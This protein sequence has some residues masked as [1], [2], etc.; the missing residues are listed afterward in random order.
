MNNNIY[1]TLLIS[2]KSCGKNYKKILIDIF[3]S[4]LIYKKSNAIRMSKYEQGKHPIY[5]RNSY[6][7]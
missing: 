4:I 1:R 3:V 5:D 7:N 6:G 2:K